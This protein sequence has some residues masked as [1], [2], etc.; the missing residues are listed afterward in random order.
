L[1]E[2]ATPGH[3]YMVWNSCGRGLSGC[4]SWTII[5]GN[6]QDSH[7]HWRRPGMRTQG[8]G[9]D[10]REPFDR[11]IY[12]PPTCSVSVFGTHNR[13]AW[14]HCQY[15]P[16]KWHIYLDQTTDLAVSFLKQLV[17]VRRPL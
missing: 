4:P 16:L 8:R 5:S 9:P 15:C 17:T 3:V 1:R 6:R 2:S 10:I 14:I 13:R 12:R 11:C 7:L